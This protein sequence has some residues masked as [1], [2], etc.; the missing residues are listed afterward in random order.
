MPNPFST[1]GYIEELPSNKTINAISTSITTFIGVALNGPVNKPTRINSFN[2]FVQQFGGLLLEST[3]SYAVQD[4]YINGGTDAIIIR[5]LPTN[6]RTR[7]GDPEYLS[8]IEVL[9]TIDQFNVLC[10]PP[11]SR[12]T[13]TSLVV[14]AAAIDLCI[15]KRAILLIDPPVNWNNQEVD[16]LSQPQQRVSDFLAHLPSTSNAA[17]YYPLINKKDPLKENSIE[18]FV[19]CGVVAGILATTDRTRGVWKSPAGLDTKM[20]GI[21]GVRVNITDNQNGLLNALGVNCLRVFT[22]SG[23]VV[24]GARTLTGSNHLASEY[25][26]IAVRRTALLIEESIYKGTKWVA[27][28]SNNEVLW[29]QIRNNVGA[30]MHSLFLKGAFQGATPKEAYFVKCDKETTTQHNIDTGVVNIIVSFA[31]LKPSEFVTLI[32]K[33]L[34]GQR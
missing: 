23:P 31:P 28:E 3:M 29:A 26:Y 17:I 12:G 13:A 30:F 5:I 32:I 15:S 2:E 10:I 34:A 4:F 9:K 11:P 33:H 6:N 20:M 1:P 25:K 14:Y 18:S 22:R 8:A 21:T 16:F 7:S 19:P 24:W 27:F